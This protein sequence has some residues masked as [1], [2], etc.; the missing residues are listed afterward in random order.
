MTTGSAR[1]PGTGRRRP[2]RRRCRRRRAAPAPGRRRRAG[3]ARRRHQCS[4]GSGRSWCFASLGSRSMVRSRRR[5][6]CSGRDGLA[7]RAGRAAGA[8]AS[9][10]RLAHSPHSAALRDG[11]SPFFGW[12]VNSASTS[13]WLAP[14]TSST[15]PCSAFFGP[16]LDE[17]PRAGVVQRVQ[18]ADELHRRG[19]L[20][21]QHVEHGLACRRQRGRSR[22][23]RWRRSAA[24]G[25]RTSSRR[26]ATFSGSLA[27]A[28]IEV[29]KAW[30]TGMRIALMPAAWKASIARSTASVAPPMTAWLLLLM[31]AMTTLPST[32]VDDPFDLRE[33]TEDRR[34]R[35]VVGHRQASPS[36]DR[37]R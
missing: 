34:H 3:R 12:L 27:G 10:G 35:S 8:P 22:R 18:A 36:R 2:A 24:S 28:T 25:A 37:V 6:R 17:D 7:E 13:S 4:W 20:A 11:T 31:L 30:L 32:D 33:R 5:R 1:R 26:S 9:R 15:K 14:R 29:W 16:D 19:D 21:T 23:S